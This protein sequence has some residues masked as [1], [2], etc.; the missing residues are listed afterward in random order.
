VRENDPRWAYRDATMAAVIDRVLGNSEP[1]A[2]TVER[3]PPPPPGGLKPPMTR[4]G[5]VCWEVGFNTAHDFTRLQTFARRSYTIPPGLRDVLLDSARS[6]RVDDVN[7]YW[8]MVDLS[9]VDPATAESELLALFK[10]GSAPQWL[11][12][13]G[14]KLLARSEHTLHKEDAANVAIDAYLRE[15]FDDPGFTP[16]QFS[17]LKRTPGFIPI[18]EEDY[19]LPLKLT[20]AE[21]RRDF[22]G[23]QLTLERMIEVGRGEFGFDL[24]NYAIDLANLEIA[25]GRKDLAMRI[26]GWLATKSA[27]P[28]KPQFDKLK[29]LLG[30]NGKPADP[31]PQKTPWDSAPRGRGKPF[32]MK[33]APASTKT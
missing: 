20:I 6:P 11:R 7:R 19:G 22:E 18:P 13:E 5:D 25:A 4:P 24:L 23:A 16:E 30:T 33:P 15:T 9:K 29:D 32:E 28:L 12:S 3:C 2:A 10:F 8:A 26:A 31:P 21:S 17:T 14:Y 1:F 27:D